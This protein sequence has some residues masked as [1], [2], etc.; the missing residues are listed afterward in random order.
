MMVSAMGPYLRPAEA[1]EYLRVSE[2]TI[3]RL[4]GERR[5]PSYS[6]AGNLTL[7]KK[8]DLDEYVEKHRREAI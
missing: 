4:V 6:L 3:K 7:L 5:L 1:A 2:R 8:Q